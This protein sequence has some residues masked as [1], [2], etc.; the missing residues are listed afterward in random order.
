MP[1]E[2]GTLPGLG[3]VFTGEAPALGVK[4]GQLSPCPGTP[5]CVVSQGADG[6]HAI[7]PISYSGSR[8][9]AQALLAKV[10]QV[11]PR[12]Q[13]VTQADGYIRAKATSR[14]MG[15]VDDLEFYFPPNQSVIHL[16]SAA[17]LGQSDLGVNRR[18]LEQIRLALRDLGI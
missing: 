7:A 10:I 4:D 1:T 6:N 9:D 11:V 3:G 5:N 17:R 12:T 16:R 2:L 8:S 15:F 13:I 14:L 18:R